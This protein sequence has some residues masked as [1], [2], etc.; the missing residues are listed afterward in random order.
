MPSWNFEHVSFTLAR[1]SHEL[2]L[3]NL[4]RRLQNAAGSGEIVELWRRKKYLQQRGRGRM[5]AASAATA[6]AASHVT[7]SAL[8]C[9]ERTASLNGIPI[10][11]RVLQSGYRRCGPENDC[12][13]HHATVVLTP[14]RASLHT[15]CAAQYLLRRHAYI[16]ICLQ[17]SRP[18]CDF[19]ECGCTVPAATRLSTLISFL[20]SD[21]DLAIM[22]EEG[23][24]RSN[25]TEALLIDR[26]IT[27]CVSWQ[28]KLRNH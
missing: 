23:V 20:H 14:L 2:G 10:E 22:W 13:R 19:A 15:C 3:L 7:A 4:C 5:G 17:P 11:D 25:T 8:T 1:A 12:D 28:R 21:C 16:Y 24:V 18:M 26:T 9:N 6:V 27:S